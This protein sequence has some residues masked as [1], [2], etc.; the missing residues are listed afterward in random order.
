MLTSVLQL[1]THSMQLSAWNITMG[2]CCF[3]HIENYLQ[4]WTGLCT[5]CRRNSWHPWYG[6]KKSVR[7][8]IFYFLHILNS[9]ETYT[10]IRTQRKS[11]HWYRKLY[12]W[13]KICQDLKSHLIRS[14]SPL[15]HFTPSYGLFEKKMLYHIT[16]DL[17]WD[18]RQFQIIGK[19]TFTYTG[20]VLCRVNK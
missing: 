18:L 8:K 15:K 14:E 7:F 3:Y 19:G 1:I 16:T 10:P 20:Q 9:S 17:V 2:N 13:K 11:N 5:L 12:E 6:L 4:K